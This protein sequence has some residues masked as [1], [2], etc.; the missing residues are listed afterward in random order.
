LVLS[1]YPGSITED[2]ALTLATPMDYKGTE[3]IVVYDDAACVLGSRAQSTRSC[4]LSLFGLTLVGLLC[5]RRW[6]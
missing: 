6:R 4:L 5:W 2:S 1:F 3:D